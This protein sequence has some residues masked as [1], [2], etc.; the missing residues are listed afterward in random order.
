[1]SCAQ[2]LIDAYIIIPA[3]SV[4]ES[5]YTYLIEEDFE[6][7]G[8]PAG[9]VSFPGPYG[10]SIIDFD[11]TTSPLEGDESLYFRQDDDGTAVQTSYTFP[12][13]IFNITICGIIKFNILPTS[14]IPVIG[15]L[16]ESLYDQNVGISLKDGNWV[17]AWGGSEDI[18]TAV[19]VGETYYFWY[20]ARNETSPGALD[21]YI[22]LY[23]SNS[24]SKP[25]VPNCEYSG[26]G[27]TG[28]KPIMLLLRGALGYGDKP[29]FVLDHLRVMRDNAGLVIDWPQ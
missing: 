28:V 21:G 20:E 17:I 19:V 5:L 15:S 23:I 29:T 7:T 26:I 24:K 22:K 9:W 8:S 6:G 3:G 11:Y 18:G 2:L 1:L 4:G 13:Q 27:A 12:E 16:D 14:Y 25:F 10:D